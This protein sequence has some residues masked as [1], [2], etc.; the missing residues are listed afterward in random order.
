MIVADFSIDVEEVIIMLPDHVNLIFLSATVPNTKEFA[1]WVGR[2]KKKKIFVISTQKRPVPLEHFLYANNELFKVVDRNSKYLT[3]GYQAAS[4]SYHQ[5]KEKK[6]GK[7]KGPKSTR[8]SYTKLIRLLGERKLLPAVIFVFSKKKCQEMAASISAD[9]N[10]SSEKGEVQSFIANCI[11]KLKGRDKNLPQVR[12]MKGLLL[13]GIGVHHGGLLPIIKEV[14]ELLF[15]RGLV[16][17]LLATETFAMGVNMPARTVIFSSIRKYDGNNWRDLLSGEYTQMSGRAGRRGLDRTG[18]VI[19]VTQ[20]EVPEPSA[21]RRMMLGKATKLESQFRLTYNM[22]LNL[23]RLGGRFRVEDMIKRSFSESGSQALNEEQKNRF[24][25]VQQKVLDIE[26]I[27]CILGEDPAP[28]FNYYHL[29]MHEREL[30]EQIQSAVL[31]SFDTKKFL[32]NGRVIVVSNEKYSNAPGIIIKKSVPKM[33]GGLSFFEESS[34]T[35]NFDV[36]VL[37]QKASSNVKELFT[38]DVISLYDIKRLCKG[39]IQVNENQLKGRM[40]RANYAQEIVDNLE[41]IFIDASP[42][43]PPAIDPVKDMK[44]KDVQFISIYNEQKRIAAELRGSKCHTCPHLKEQFDLVDKQ[45]KANKKIEAMK[46]M[47]SEESLNLKPDFD[48]RVA[49]L[50]QLKYISDTKIIQL[51]G[52]VARE[53]STINELIATEIIFENLLTPLSPAEIAALLSCLVFQEGGGRK[54]DVPN[55]T[56]RLDEVYGTMYEIAVGIANIQI[57]CG[58]MEDVGDFLNDNVNPGLMNVVFEW[59]NGTTFQEICSMT[60]VQEGSIV[61]TMVRLDETCR[62][63]RNAGRI[64]GDLEMSKKLEEASQLIKRDIVFASSLYLD[65]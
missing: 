27:T 36:F 10:T 55:V 40:F 26:D 35:P 62:D 22:I 15:A 64:I 21:M 14:V 58:I 45:E 53:V 6:G 49:V 13:R 17:V 59:A 16:K 41:R 56:E 60:E 63:F 39:K 30:S 37:T 20:D 18:V 42:M 11:A 24:E 48:A 33:G 50:K 19:V 43:L 47:L 5:L 28:I 25:T 12:V 54:Q 31:N 7:K 32:G 34:D 1:E 61:R 51:K 65:S 23:L 4:R 3:K 29:Y 2:T 44:I 57:S 38:L 8:G 52:K 46:F 9:L